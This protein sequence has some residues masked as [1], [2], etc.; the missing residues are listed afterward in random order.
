MPNL[1]TIKRIDDLRTIWPHEAHDFTTWLAKEENLALLSEEIGIDI[2]LTEVE[3]SVGSFNVDIFAAEE[4]TTRKIIIENQLEDTNHD[5][6]GKIITYASG[7]NAEIIIW[8]VKHARDEHRQA[9]EWLNQHTDEDIGFFL[10]EIELWAIDNSLPAPKFNVIERPN[11]WA[12]T[13]KAAEG[14]TDI[15][16]LQLEFWSAFNEEAFKRPEI[17][18]FFRKRKPQPQN[19]YTLST[20]RSDCELS[21]A[22]N[23]QRQRIGAEIYVKGNKE[24][25]ERYLTHK[26]E[27]EQEF[28]GKAEWIEAKKDCRI[29]FSHV[30]DIR[31]RD[32]WP[33]CFDWY[34]EMLPKLKKVAERYAI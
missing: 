21:L 13:M 14:M 12:K 8:I 11:D 7:K 30:G 19:W 32:Q 28:G 9:V 5:H 25:F 27:I 4:G 22:A 33:A 29:V 18:G 24:L 6:L 2:V 1:G 31:D 16:R 17:K 15:K 26:D 34:C 3:S 10:V 23:S 20:G